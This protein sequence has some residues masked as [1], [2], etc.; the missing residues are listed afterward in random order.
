MKK[1]VAVLFC[2]AAV[3]A[4]RT[5]FYQPAQPQYAGK[6]L[7]YWLREA[8]QGI[9]PS[10]EAVTAIR[11]IGTNGIPAYLGMLHAKGTPLTTW[12][13]FGDGTRLINEGM[14]G[15]GRASSSLGLAEV[16]GLVVLAPLGQR[17]A[18]DLRY[19][20][21]E[22]F[23]ILREAG[24]P[25]TVGLSNLLYRSDGYR[26]PARDPI[27]RSK[28]SP[29]FQNWR[30]QEDAACCLGF[31][32]PA[33]R[34]VLL[35]GLE[36][37]DPGIRAAAA[38]G[39]CLGRTNDPVVVEP[40]VRHLHDANTSVRILVA[41]S[42]GLVA[43]QLGQGTNAASVAAISPMVAP[44]MRCLSEGDRDLRCY[45]AIAL[46]NCHSAEALPLIEDL[47]TNGS[48]G[49]GMIPSLITRAL[50]NIIERPVSYGARRSKVPGP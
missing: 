31:I 16:I 9:Q 18:N 38:H 33:G 39:L 43:D 15:D 4:L 49:S 10:T 42:L 34:A 23:F 30:R 24:A 11:S 25:A 19:D 48:I 2:L 20:A 13:R 14:V 26:W 7:N 28:R 21:L 36:N 41:W 29:E 22:A 37:S 35:Q 32:G 1:C 40:L 44:L 8:R 12:V 50:T 45:A 17:D 27:F 47:V 46:G 6:P 3:L 5:L